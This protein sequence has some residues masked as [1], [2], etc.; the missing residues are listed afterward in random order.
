M[1]VRKEEMEGGREGGKR[2][3]E[4]GWDGGIPQDRETK[5]K[6]EEI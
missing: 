4:T 1:D 2:D 6:D 3:L 5:G